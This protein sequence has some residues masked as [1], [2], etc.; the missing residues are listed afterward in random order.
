MWCTP[1]PGLP[2]EC[3]LE[4]GKHGNRRDITPGGSPLIPR[5]T[6]P[7]LPGGD[8]YGRPGNPPLASG[9]PPWYHDTVR[10]RERHTFHYSLSCEFSHS[11]F[12]FPCLLQ[13]E[14][15][16]RTLPGGIGSPAQ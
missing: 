15:R 7:L 9:S 14:H 13:P 1:R 10:G 3:G 2:P 6:A 8:R 16:F 11:C 12:S 4:G 5:C